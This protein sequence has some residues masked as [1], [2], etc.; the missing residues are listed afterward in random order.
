[1]ALTL[2]ILDGRKQIFPLPSLDDRYKSLKHIWF[3]QQ[4]KF[5][6]PKFCYYN[7]QVCQC[8]LR[9]NKLEMQNDERDNKNGNR[10]NEK[11]Q[12][13]CQS[14][15]AVRK[16]KQRENTTQFIKAEAERKANAR[17]RI[18]RNR[19]MTKKR[20][21]LQK[22]E[23]ENMRRRKTEKQHRWREKMRQG[24]PPDMLPVGARSNGI[25]QQ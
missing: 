20:N 25:L 24:Q 2:N 17:E 7:L 22:L 5:N 16:R 21:E 23:K 10:K 9:F 14:L 18:R 1:M 8:I 3:M 19:A 15:S 6:I 11:N 4:T 12:E 13:N